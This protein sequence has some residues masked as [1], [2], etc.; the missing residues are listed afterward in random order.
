VAIDQHDLGLRVRELVRGTDTRE[1]AAE[2]EHPRARAGPRRA[3][4]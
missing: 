2:D 3:V 1:P 4:A